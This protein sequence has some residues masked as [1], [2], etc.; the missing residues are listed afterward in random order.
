MI[1]FQKGVNILGNTISTTLGIRTCIPISS[2]NKCIPWGWKL[3]RLACTAF[4]KIKTRIKKVYTFTQESTL[5]TYRGDGSGADF[6]VL[7]EGEAEPFVEGDA[8]VV[9]LV[10]P[11]EHLLAHLLPDR[12]IHRQIERE[13]QR[14]T[15]RE[16]KR[17]REREADR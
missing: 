4:E 12:Q 7:L 1:L 3:R 11:L 13:R 9:V 5:S 15:E 10:D 14:E 2:R 17:E 8:A 16:T 6:L